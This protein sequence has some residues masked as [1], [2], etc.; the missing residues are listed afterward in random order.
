MPRPTRISATRAEEA[1]EARQPELSRIHKMVGLV[2]VSCIA[3]AAKWELKLQHGNV[4]PGCGIWR[5][6]RVF[7]PK[8]NK[9]DFPLT[10]TNPPKNQLRALVLSDYSGVVP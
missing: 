5:I 1:R 2:V 4:D 6:F 8:K 10:S 7:P 9:K 3:S